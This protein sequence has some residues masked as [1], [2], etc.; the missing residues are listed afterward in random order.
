MLRR[1]AAVPLFA[2]AGLFALRSWNPLDGYLDGYRDSPDGVYLTTA[3]IGMALAALFAAIGLALVS[4]RF[5]RHGGF[6][7]IAG[8]AVVA[9]LLPALLF[10]WSGSQ[11][12]WP[13]PSFVEEGIGW[14]RFDRLPRAY[15]FA[16]QIGL[17]VVALTAAVAQVRTWRD[18]PGAETGAA[19]A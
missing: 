4:R 8:L 9:S 13:W 17:A 19:S 6:L 1:A 18:R 14:L 10:K 11:D 5:R 7:A 12:T 16:I 2:L 15:G 3:G